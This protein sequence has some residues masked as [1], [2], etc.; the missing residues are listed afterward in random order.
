MW[1]SQFWRN[2]YDFCS[3]API[4]TWSGSR[5]LTSS[6][7]RKWDD[8][9][10]IDGNCAHPGHWWLPLLRCAVCV[11]MYYDRAH[12]LHDLSGWKCFCPSGGGRRNS[13]LSVI[14][15]CHQRCDD[16]VAQFATIHHLGC[17]WVCVCVFVREVFPDIWVQQFG[18]IRHLFPRQQQLSSYSIRLK[19]KFLR[20]SNH[21]K[22]TQWVCFCVC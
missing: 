15:V 12:D 7:D 9:K 2:I 18:F 11:C 16:F 1:R 4:V 8:Q 5:Q 22:I 6:A 14:F 20:C 17:V 19:T 3:P 21:I 13:S 10:F